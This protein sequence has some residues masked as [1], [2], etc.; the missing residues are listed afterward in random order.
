M[1]AKRILLYVFKTNTLNNVQS[2][3]ST[4]N[5]VLYQKTSGQWFMQSMFEGRARPPLFG[6]PGV[7]ADANDVPS[8]QLVV[9]GHKGLLRFVG[10]GKDMMNKHKKHCAIWGLCGVSSK[11]KP[12]PWV[13]HNLQLETL[14]PQ[15][16]EEQLG[17]RLS[18]GMDTACIKHNIIHILLC[19]WINNYM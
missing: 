13:C 15:V 3:C 7:T 19:K 2:L 18:L 8:A 12:A 9:Y 14:S 5:H 17:T 11:I 1:W 6:L 10:P 4:E 16:V